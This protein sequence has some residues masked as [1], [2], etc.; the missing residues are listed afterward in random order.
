MCVCVLRVFVLAC[1]CELCMFA[2]W[3]FAVCGIWVGGW[4]DELTVKEHCH[5]NQDTKAQKVSDNIQVLHFYRY[6][7]NIYRP[8]RNKQKHK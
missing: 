8:K 7:I 3:Y 2:L 6:Q 4:G 5:K 1:A